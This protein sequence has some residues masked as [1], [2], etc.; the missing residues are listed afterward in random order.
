MQVIYERTE[1]MIYARN[2]K[3]NFIANIQVLT[4]D[5]AK[6]VY[7]VYCELYYHTKK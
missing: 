5:M 2:D 7:I 3:S 6:C 1:V 4:G